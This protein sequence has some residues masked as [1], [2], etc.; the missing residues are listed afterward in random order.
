MPL[1]WTVD[2]QGGLRTFNSGAYQIT[3][4]HHGEEK[5]YDCFHYGQQ[6][7]QVP[8]F[9]IELAKELCDIYEGME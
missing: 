4:S 8:R 6:I 7:N 3:E 2:Y 9:T 5:K 1:K